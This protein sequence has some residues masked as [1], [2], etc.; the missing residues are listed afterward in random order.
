M[1]D[2]AS[3]SDE[4]TRSSDLGERPWRPT[5]PRESFF[6]RGGSR[7]NRISSDDCWP[8]VRSD[9]TTWAGDKPRPPKETRP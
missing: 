5:A 8:L 7:V 4:R 9:G 2:K 6:D 1:V 3:K